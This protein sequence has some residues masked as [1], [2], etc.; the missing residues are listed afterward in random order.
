MAKGHVLV[1][2]LEVGSVLGLAKQLELVKDMEW[3]Q[4]QEP[5]LV[6]LL[7]MKKEA[8]MVAE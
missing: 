5:M 4:G 8:V 6:E 7:A 3:E 1:L 2:K